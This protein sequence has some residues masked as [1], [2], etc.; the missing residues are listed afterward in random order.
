MSPWGCSDLL[1]LRDDLAAWQGMLHLEVDSALVGLMAEANP[2]LLHWRGVYGCAAGRRICTVW[3]DGCVTP[4]SFLTGCS[5]S[6]PP[7]QSFSA[8]NVHQAPFAELWA[9]G[10]NW[11]GLRDTAARPQGDCVGCA[12]AQQC[13]GVRCVARYERADPS[14]GDAECPSWRAQTNCAP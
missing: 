6:S 10:M 9:R 3:P 14:A 8:G 13:G 2:A 7:R 1:R 4:C 5:G 11:E 12:V